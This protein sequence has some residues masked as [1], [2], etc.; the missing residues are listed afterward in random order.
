MAD[1]VKF[2]KNVRKFARVNSDALL[3]PECSTF[4]YNGIDGFIG[5][6]VIGRSAIVFGEPAS[7][8]EDKLLLAEAFLLFCQE[9]SLDFVYTMTGKQ[10][11][12][13]CQKEICPIRMQF[14]Y[15]LTIDPGVD[16]LAKRGP[17]GVLLR[18]KIKH[19]LK[20]GVDIQEYQGGNPALESEIT[21]MGRAWQSGR[22]GPQIYLAPLKIF[23]DP[24]GKRW[25]VAKK[26]N[27][28]VGL[29]QLNQIG[30]KGTWL[31]NNLITAKEAPN[32]TSESL[33]IRALTLLKEEGS[34]GA[35]I[36][37]IVTED[38]T[39][40]SGLSKTT[41]YIVRLIFQGLKKVFSLNGQAKF[42]EKFDPSREPSFLLFNKMNVGAIRSLLQAMHSPF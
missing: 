1:R 23:D 31:L 26:G 11:A 22:K 4:T 34:K 27:E 41:S 5:Y 25:L 28:T 13:L 14:A 35:V 40:I 39:E 24:A 38:L 7:A 8:D 12:I 21:V 18:K 17:H 37:P 2:V 9:N 32:G 3:D 36:G 10:F 29:L 6:R 15:N 16:Q 42:W 19:A 33:V 20:E 30:N